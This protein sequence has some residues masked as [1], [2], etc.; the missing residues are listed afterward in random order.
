MEIVFVLIF[1]LINGIFQNEKNIIDMELNQEEICM[2]ANIHFEANGE[3]MLG[4]IAVAQVVNQRVMCKDYAN[5][6]CQVISSGAGK[7]GCA[8]SW[9]CD[10]KN[11]DIYLLNQ[12]EIDSWNENVHI[13][14]VMTSETPFEI[15]QLKEVT[16][17]HAVNKKPWWANDK[18]VHFVAK[19]GN[20]L[21]YKED[22]LCEELKYQ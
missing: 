12:Y 14:R 6:V 8:F 21:F 19:I 7:S 5:D 16:L 15:E 20:H 11:N 17:F 10:K 4:K 18:S 1:S 22:G 2:T 9:Q 3:K 13:A